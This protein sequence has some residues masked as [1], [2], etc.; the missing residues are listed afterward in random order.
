MNTKLKTSIASP[1]EVVHDHI[2]LSFPL[3]FLRNKLR[4]KHKVC[5]SFFFPKNVTFNRKR[6]DNI[7]MGVSESRNKLLFLR[8]QRCEYIQVLMASS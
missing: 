4:S 6:Q 7:W 1:K 3:D 2:E 8:Q 5:F